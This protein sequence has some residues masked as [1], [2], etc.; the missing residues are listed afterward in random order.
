MAIIEE[1][2]D[3]RAN[4]RLRQS[5]LKI[6]ALFLC[7]IGLRAKAAPPAPDVPPASMTGQ[8]FTTNAG[9]GVPAVPN[10]AIGPLEEL[11]SFMLNNDTSTQPWT[12]NLFSLWEAAAFQNVNGVAGV[13]P[14]GNDLGLEIPIHKYNIHLDSV[15]EFE[16]VFGDVHSQAIGIAYDYNLYQIQLS[17]GLD[18]E[19]GLA[20]AFTIHAEPYFEFK[21]ASTALPALAPF[22]RY[23]YPIRSRAG[24]GKIYIGVT[25]SMPKLL[26]IF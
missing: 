6:I 14:V 9:P 8:P 5:H 13:S 22:I 12:S 18:A 7:L 10:A 2:S 17:A 3:R 15:T 19:M 4:R 24:A 11:Q 26:K 20:K 23:G 25:I 21:K 16:T 1:V